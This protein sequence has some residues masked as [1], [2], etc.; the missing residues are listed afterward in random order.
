M[1]CYVAAITIR[2]YSSVF[3]LILKLALYSTADGVQ[4]FIDKAIDMD[5][6]RSF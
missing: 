3:S 4:Y 5:E 6:K 1:F 2:N